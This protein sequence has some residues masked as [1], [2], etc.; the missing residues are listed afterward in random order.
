MG[1]GIMSGFDD[2]WYEK[3]DRER[4]A[5]WDEEEASFEGH[6]EGFG[7][8]GWPTADREEHFDGQ[9]DRFGEASSPGQNYQAPPPTTASQRRTNPRASLTFPRRWLWTVIPVIVLVGGGGAFFVLSGH[10][11]P[12]HLHIEFPKAAGS[13]PLDVGDPFSVDNEQWGEVVSR[14]NL[15]DSLSYKVTVRIKPTKAK[16]LR[17]GTIFYVRSDSPSLGAMLC[18]DSS[19]RLLGD[20]EEVVGVGCYEDA[21]KERIRMGLDD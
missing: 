7:G 17:L 13:M 12:I 6:T 15:L 21:I 3:S 4:D 1:F 2:R 11:E 19:N 20:Q 18:T 10:A 14:D 9:S 5:G 8:L 16:R